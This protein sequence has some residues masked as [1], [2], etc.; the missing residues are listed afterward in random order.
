MN[1]HNGNLDH[2]TSLLPLE[3]QAK[4]KDNKTLSSHVERRGCARVRRGKGS[5]TI[6]LERM[7]ASEPVDCR[8]DSVASGLTK[9]FGASLAVIVASEE[10]GWKIFVRK[11]DPALKLEGVL[12]GA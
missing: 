2:L 6:Q 1:G 9:R 8:L 7:E 4:K 12:D 5:I 11:S 3:E 10:G